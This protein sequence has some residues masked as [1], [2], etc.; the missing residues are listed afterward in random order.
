MDYH[1]YLHN[2]TSGQQ[3]PQTTPKQVKP[4]EQRTSGK[5]KPN[6]SG[7]IAT[8]TNLITN[9]DSLISSAMSKSAGV[10]KTVGKFVVPL[11]ITHALYRITDK[12]ATEYFAITETA[13]GDYTG[14]FVLGNIKQS[15]HN[16][17]HPFSTVF[18]SFKAQHQIKIGNMRTEQ[19]R[20]LLGGTIYNSNYGRYL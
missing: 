5:T 3:A 20:L 7:M 2:S 6:V 10:L 1:I 15:I 8:T 18:S 13:S 14:S 19:E 17:T 9:P 4:I 12:I 11:F 16:L